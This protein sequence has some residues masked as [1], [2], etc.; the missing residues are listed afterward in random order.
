MAYTLRTSQQLR[1]RWWVIPRLI[2]TLTLLKFPPRWWV[3]RHRPARCPR[4]TLIWVLSRQTLMSSPVK[5]SIQQSL[6]MQ[7]TAILFKA[8]MEE[9]WDHNSILHWPMSTCSVKTVLFWMKSIH[10]LPGKVLTTLSQ[11]TTSR[12]I[13]HLWIVI[14]RETRLHN[15]SAAIRRAAQGKAIWTMPVRVSTLL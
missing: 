3:V 8:P 15:T 4:D 6:P 7:M 1:R 9:K 2:H 11:Q 13:R 14:D 10:V 5:Q 12:R